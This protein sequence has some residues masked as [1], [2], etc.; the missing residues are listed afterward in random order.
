MALLALFTGIKLGQKHMAGTNTL[1]YFAS[2]RKVCYHCL[3]ATNAL[4]YLSDSLGL[5]LAAC[6]VSIVYII[7]RNV[8]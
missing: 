3:T 5:S 2:R 1:T 8:G 6:N 4:A 7:I